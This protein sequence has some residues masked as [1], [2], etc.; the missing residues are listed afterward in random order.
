MK[1][2]IK[3]IIIIGKKTM[4]TIFNKLI[5]FEINVTSLLYHIIFLFS[6]IL[7]Y[8]LL[9]LATTNIFTCIIFLRALIKSIIWCV[10]I[11][12]IISLLNYMSD[13]DEYIEKIF[14]VV[15]VIIGAFSVLIVF[16]LL[17]KDL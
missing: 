17:N 10:C 14:C 11:D 4:K 2:Y 8:L 13:D 6:F 1:K 5:K 7:V 3:K 15:P 12:L 9:V 16:L